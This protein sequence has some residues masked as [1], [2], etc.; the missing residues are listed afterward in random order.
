MGQI[1]KC[2]HTEFLQEGDIVKAAADLDYG[3]VGHVGD[4]LGATVK[5]GSLGT[6]KTPVSGSG[7]QMVEWSGRR[8]GHTAVNKDQIRKCEYTEFLQEGDIVK[9]AADLDYG[10]VGH[11]G[12]EL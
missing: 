6:L 3:E 12:D 5:K 9:A 2:E 4:E 11:V 1:R 8:L 7:C 10:E